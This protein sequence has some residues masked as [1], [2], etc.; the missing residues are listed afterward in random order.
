MP[1]RH[2]LPAFVLV[3]AVVAFP[4][5]LQAQVSATP[6][7]LSFGNGVIGTT[8]G[9]SS[10][11]LKNAT[12]SAITISS[13]TPT[14]NFNVQTTTCGSSLGAGKSCKI[15]VNFSPSSLGPVTGTL[16]IKDTASNSP[17]TV[18]LSGTGIQPCT[19]S[20]ASL[21]FGNTAVGNSSA[22]QTLTLQNNQ[23]VPLTITS[24]QPSGDFSQTNSCPLSPNTLAA[25][26][27]CKISAKFSPTALGP[28]TG[29]ISVSD[30]ANNSPQATSLTGTGTMPVSL[31]PNSLNF[32][33]QP[34]GTT[35]AAQTVTLTNNQNIALT[36]NSI[37]ANSDFS[38]SSTTC[39]ISPSTVAA[40]ASCGISVKFTPAAR[41][42]PM[43]AG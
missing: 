24:I 11:T 31:S 19:L 18:A 4:I 10:V 1:G 42:E 22:T 6:T 16:S 29:T 27:S 38:V 23:S 36:I 34:Y 30:N 28:R 14:A 35:S 12:S 2:F 25:G 43:A 33:N 26:R 21:T 32:G 7:S 5:G 20:P 40:G 17:Q 37:Q 8:S 15:S 41:E 9:A 3:A 39:P 13:V